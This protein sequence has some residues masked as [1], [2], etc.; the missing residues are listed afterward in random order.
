MLQS[1]FL[2]PDYLVNG[3]SILV[4]AK[5]EEDQLFNTVCNII[6]GAQRAQFQAFEII[7]ID[8]GS[9][10]R[11]TLIANEL[12]DKLPFIRVIRN[13]ISQGPGAL[14]IRAI[15][16]AKFSKL[17]TFAGD[18][19]AHSDLAE[20]IFNNWDK[21]DVVVSYFLNVEHRSWFRIFLS[22]IYTLIYNTVFGLH[23]KYINGNSVYPI[24]LLKELDLRATSYGIFAEVLVKSLRKGVTFYEVAGY[25]NPD[26]MKSQA[27]TLRNF[28]K[29]VLGFLRL[30]WIVFVSE[31]EKYQY[32]P[33]RAHVPAFKEHKLIPGQS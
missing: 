22:A 32:L 8:D 17:T 7:I 11:T 27:L 19:N 2:Y 30:V 13:E 33:R 25:A 9:I 18:N 12:S 28:S 15:G 16:E 20:A 26:G 5:N 3:L 1:S 24:K 4:P 23:L 31:R 21:A 6:E 10:D 29:I 14:L